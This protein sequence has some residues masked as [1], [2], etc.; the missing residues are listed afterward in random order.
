MNGSNRY[1]KVWPVMASAHGEAEVTRQPILLRE[2]VAGL[3]QHFFERYFF[4][5]VREIISAHQ[6]HREGC[7]GE[8]K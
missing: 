4:E 5:C 3:K 8:A 1:S 2:F 6:Q 7:S